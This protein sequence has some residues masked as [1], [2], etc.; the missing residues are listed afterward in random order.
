MSEVQNEK[1]AAEFPKKQ[2]ESVFLHSLR[3]MDQDREY[4]QM[5]LKK[6]SDERTEAAFSDMELESARLERTIRELMELSAPIEAG[7]DVEVTLECAGGGTSR[8]V[9]VAKPF[10]GG[11]ESYQPTAPG[12]ASGSPT[13]S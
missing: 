2:L 8:F 11:A 6:V 12:D 3:L 5:H 13:A 4:L 10:E 9:A 1:D 7:S